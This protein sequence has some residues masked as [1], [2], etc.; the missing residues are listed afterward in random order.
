LT[1]DATTIPGVGDDIEPTTKV[2]QPTLST[3]DYMKVYYDAVGS[4]NLRSVFDA[5]AYEIRDGQGV[6]VEKIRVLQG[7]KLVLMDNLSRGVLIS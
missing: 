3:V 4:M 6:L 5:W 2:Q 1:K 7:G